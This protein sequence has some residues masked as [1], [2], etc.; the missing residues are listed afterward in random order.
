MPEEA[1]RFILHPMETLHSDEHASW[2][3]R[4]PDGSVFGP[5]S[6]AALKQW[7]ADGRIGPD[8]DLSE[9]R[10]HWQPAPALSP[11]DMSWSIRLNEE[12]FFGP[13]HLMAL[14]SIVEEAHLSYSS[15]ALHVA[16]GETYKLGDV[17]IPLLLSQLEVRSGQS[18]AQ[19]DSE[20]VRALSESRHALQREMT[21]LSEELSQC[22][23]QLLQKTKEQKDLTEK[24]MVA[25]QEKIERQE[26]DSETIRLLQ[27]EIE[28]AAEFAARTEAERDEASKERDQLKRD[29]ETARELHKKTVLEKESAQRA[30]AEQEEALRLGREQEEQLRQTEMQRQAHQAEIESKLQLIQVEKKA[31]EED[32]EQ[33]RLKRDELA[34]RWEEERRQW[35]ERLRD[36][37]QAQAKGDRERAAARKRIEELEK[38]PGQANVKG[39]P[40]EADFRELEQ[41]LAHVRAILQQREVQLQRLQSSVRSS[42]SSLIRE[43]VRRKLPVSARPD[44]FP[45]GEIP[46]PKASAVAAI[47]RNSLRTEREQAARGSRSGR[48][49][50]DE[51]QI[52][53]AGRPRTSHSAAVERRNKE[54]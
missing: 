34:A 36:S 31:W 16:S 1:I 43:A 49:N 24:A 39:R 48:P 23:K 54:R 53:Q 32:R 6:L 2:F 35:E 11:L 42:S 52:L 7:A 12:G 4:K 20:Q 3:V 19:E 9:D 50:Q 44:F 15:E 17:L 21:L 40:T 38:E 27:A 5:A 25:H 51:R 29:L 26:K 10:A 33:M 18:S 37:E 28:H 14:T 13:F 22:K 45:E 46:P 47:H 41:E 30:S 8:D